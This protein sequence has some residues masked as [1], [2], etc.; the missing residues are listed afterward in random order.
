MLK[1]A[2]LVFLISMVPVIE[3]RGAIPV[4]ILTDGL[5]PWLV[6]ILA[7]IGNMLPVPFILLFIRKILNW[8]KGRP[9]LGKIAIKLEERAEKKSGKVRQSE[10]VGLCLFVAIPLP[11]TGAWT[12]ALIAALMKMRIRRALPTILLG[13]V[14]AGVAVTLILQFGSGILKEIFVG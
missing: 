11:G 3:L 14:T 6:C 9:R 2:I 4:G 10:L 7:I 8:M 12:G 1:K 13:V 5:S